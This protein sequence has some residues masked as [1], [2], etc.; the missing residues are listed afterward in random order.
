[1]GYIGHQVSLDS[2]FNL[3]LTD[4]QIYVGIINIL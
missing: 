4:K 2:V 1:M 3:L